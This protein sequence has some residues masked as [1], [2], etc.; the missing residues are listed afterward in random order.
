MPKLEPPAELS[1]ASTYGSTPTVVSA[2]MGWLRRLIALLFHQHAFEIIEEGV[3]MHGPDRYRYRL[4]KCKALKGGKPCRKTRSRVAIHGMLFGLLLLASSAS[5]QTF[6]RSPEL[7]AGL[8]QAALQVQPCGN[9]LVVDLMGNSDFE[10]E[11]NAPGGLYDLFFNTTYKQVR[12][13]MLRFNRNAISGKT[14]SEL[15]HSYDSAWAILDQKMASLGAQPCS[16]QWLFILMTQ[17]KPYN[18]DYGP[19]TVEKVEATLQNY[20]AKRPNVKGITILSMNPTYC[21]ACLM[22]TS[23]GEQQDALFQAYAG[24]HYGLPVDYI[25][26]W[27]IPGWSLAMMDTDLVHENVNPGAPYLASWAAQQIRDSG[28]YC[29]M[30]TDQ[31]CLSTP[32][33]PPPPDPVYGDLAGAQRKWY[34]G[35]CSLVSGAMETPL[36]VAWCEGLK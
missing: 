27:R 21:E 19:A 3:A 31:P 34:N 4:E 17:Q 13:A 30:F 1:P 10:R 20:L 26:Q 23:A 2:T 11:M 12:A 36:P 5:A 25:Q 7:V 22:P 29:W 16:S 14:L 18:P 24:M 32:P 35:A 6:Q 28:F 33:P 15:Q 8:Q 9:L